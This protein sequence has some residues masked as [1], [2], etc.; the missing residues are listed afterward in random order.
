MCASVLSPILLS[1]HLRQGCQLQDCNTLH[2]AFASYSLSPGSPALQRRGN[3]LTPGLLC[4]SPKKQV[5]PLGTASSLPVRTADLVRAVLAPLGVTLRRSMHCNGRDN[6]LS[7][8]LSLS[9]SIISQDP[10]FLS[11]QFPN[12]VTP[13]FVMPRTPARRVVGPVLWYLTLSIRAPNSTTSLTYHTPLKNVS[14][15]AGQTALAFG[16]GL[17]DS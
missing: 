16:H 12:T 8:S 15:Q 3:P 10:H 7:K 1:L 11:A 6:C 14:R 17:I 13:E 4:Y 2:N 9:L 5:Q